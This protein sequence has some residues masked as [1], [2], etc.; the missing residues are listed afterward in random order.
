ML[1]GAIATAVA[2]RRPLCD[3]CHAIRRRVRASGVQDPR[4]KKPMDISRL[5]AVPLFAGLPLS[6]RAALAAIAGEAR[7][8]A[9]DVL[10]RDG[11]FLYE[12]I[13]IESG[14]A[15]LFR[16]DELIQRLSTGDVVGEIGALERHVGTATVVARTPM[17]LITLNALD[18]R[19]LRRGDP[20]VVARM[21][22]RLLRR[23]ARR[24][25]AF[26]PC[27]VAPPQRV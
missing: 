15:E 21:Q 13:A 14:E 27:R 20:A 7:A 2:G 4:R 24:G 26:T 17:R 25:A 22:G 18:L 3:V 8:D 10:A 11:E 6:D 16:G 9:G 23:Q 12:L 19:R 5:D 1:P